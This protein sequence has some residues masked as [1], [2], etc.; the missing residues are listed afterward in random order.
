[1]CILAGAYPSKRHEGSPFGAADQQR[2]SWRGPLPSRGGLLQIRA[3][4]AWYKQVFAFPSWSGRAICWLCKAYKSR[5]PY[6]DFSL[7][8]KWRK[9]R[10][11]RGEFW[12]QMRASG[13]SFSLPGVT[14]DMGTIDVLHALDLGVSQDVIGNVLCE[15]L[16]S[17]ICAGRTQKQQLADLWGETQV[18]LPDLADA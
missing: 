1:M 10:Y 18:A 12:A 3:D 4:W 6:W 13:L 7:G 15:F 9:A 5:H 2:A 8:A 17:G 14:L 11:G 16:R